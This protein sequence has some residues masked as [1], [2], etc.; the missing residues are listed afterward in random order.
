MLICYN[1][2]IIEFRTANRISLDYQ[3]T[4]SQFYEDIEKYHTSS[5][6][7]SSEDKDIATMACP[8]YVTLPPTDK[9]PDKSAEAE[10]ESVQQ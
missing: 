5:T 4:D 2:S 3:T 10:Y 8:A 6:N 1:H 9:Q 7:A